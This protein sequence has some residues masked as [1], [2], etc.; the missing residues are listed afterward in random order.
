MLHLL[1]LYSFFFA[2]LLIAVRFAVQERCISPLHDYLLNMG[3]VQSK[4]DSTKQ[5]EG[6]QRASHIRVLCQQLS[7]KPVPARTQGKEGWPESSAVTCNCLS[8][9][10]VLRSCHRLAH[11]SIPIK[12]QPTAE[13]C[14]S[15]TDLSLQSQRS[16]FFAIRGDWSMF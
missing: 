13:L 2:S 8:E 1:H 9:T 12:T 10:P 3:T 4:W 16:P 5:G 11:I 7:K 6:L 14:A 15:G